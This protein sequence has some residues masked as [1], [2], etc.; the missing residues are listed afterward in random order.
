MHISSE[1]GAIFFDSNNRLRGWASRVVER[2]GGLSRL[3]S[4]DV[5]G[6]DA[7]LSEFLTHLD[8]THIVVRDRNTEST[9]Y[10]FRWASGYTNGSGIR[11]QGML[12]GR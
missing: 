5:E 3:T 11:V 9:L 1:G 10:A 6:A 12:E 8:R 7:G 4:I 2:T